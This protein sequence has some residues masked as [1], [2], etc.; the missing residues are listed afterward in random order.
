MMQRLESLA[1]C[2][3]LRVYLTPEPLGLL[4]SLLVRGNLPGGETKPTRSQEENETKAPG[5]QATHTILL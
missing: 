5:R 4:E 1:S 3:E 2:L